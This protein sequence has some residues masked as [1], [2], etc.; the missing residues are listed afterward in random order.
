MDGEFDFLRRKNQL[1]LLTNDFEAPI[2]AK[3]LASLG[4]D[5][6]ARVDT[7]GFRLDVAD[8]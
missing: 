6:N 1:N 5:A 7:C 2:G 3:D 8:V 4:A